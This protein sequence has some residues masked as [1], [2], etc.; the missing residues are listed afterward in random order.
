MENSSPIILAIDQGSGSTKALAINLNGEVLAQFDVKIATT[1]PQSGW[2]EQDPNDW[3]LSFCKAVEIAK[4][5][6]PHR[7][8]KGGRCAKA[9]H[10][11]RHIGGRATGCECDPPGGVTPWQ[12]DR[13]GLRQD[14]PHQIPYRHNCSC[15]HDSFLCDSKNAACSGVFGIAY[16]VCRCIIPGN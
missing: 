2:V 15:A 16:G 5:I 8:Y 6:G 7:P 9:R 4:G 3:W 1:F 10:P 12:Q 13:I 11:S 14:I